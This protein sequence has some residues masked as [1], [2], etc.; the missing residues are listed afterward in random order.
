MSQKTYQPSEHERLD[1][2]HKGYVSP[3]LRNPVPETQQTQSEQPP[4]KGSDD[5]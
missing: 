2:L 4:Q 5:D 3:P 1:E